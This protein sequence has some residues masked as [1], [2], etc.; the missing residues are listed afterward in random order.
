MRVFEMYPHFSEPLMKSW[1]DLQPN[2]FDDFKRNAYVFWVSVKFQHVEWLCF[3][4]QMLL[5]RIQQF[6]DSAFGPRRGTIAHKRIK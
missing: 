3:E 2:R 1:A 4:E 6:H 5:D